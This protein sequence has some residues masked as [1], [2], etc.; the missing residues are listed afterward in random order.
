MRGATGVS[1]A[2]RLGMPAALLIFTR[3]PLA[4]QEDGYLRLVDRTKDLI[5][6]GGEWIPSV[7]ARGL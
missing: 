4:P 3:P 1:I 7:Q 2:L 6:T 5:K